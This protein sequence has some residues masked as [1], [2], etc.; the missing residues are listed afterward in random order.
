MTDIAENPDQMKMAVQIKPYA[1]KTAEE[2]ELEIK[3]MKVRSKRNL[4][5]L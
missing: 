1:S 5:R 4:M 3:S 2:T